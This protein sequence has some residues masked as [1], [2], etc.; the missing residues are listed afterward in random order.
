MSDKLLSLEEV[1]KLLDKPEVTVRR[2]ARE[3]LLPSV[4]Q[5]G[6]LMFPEKSV[7]QYMDIEKRL[8]R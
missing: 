5:N 2:Y 7:Q 4:Q 8:K 1:C 6:K 3:S